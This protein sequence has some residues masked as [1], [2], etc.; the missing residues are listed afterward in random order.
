MWQTD[1]ITI[2]TGTLTSGL[3]G[4]EYT[5]ADDY[6]VAC[7]VQDISR[8]KVLKDYGFSY[9]GKYYQVFDLT[10]D[11][12]W[13]ENNQVKYGGK[14]YWVR[15]VDNSADKIGASNHIYIILNEVV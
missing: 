8:E 3:A 1:T 5:W 9:P 13:A 10:L 11:S 14:Q 12:G 7:D 4:E 2:Q 6:T 15:K